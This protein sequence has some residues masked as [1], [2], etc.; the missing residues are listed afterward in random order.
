LRS[1]ED[2]AVA[3]QYDTSGEET[4]FGDTFDGGFRNTCANPGRRR[5]GRLR[6]PRPAGHA[7]AIIAALE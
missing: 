2:G 5:R 1:D 4:T 6:G 3:S 7:E